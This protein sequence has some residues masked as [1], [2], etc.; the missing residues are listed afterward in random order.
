MENNIVL[1]V[2]RRLDNR[3]ENLPDDSPRA[4]E[5]HNRRK[6]AL[7]EILDNQEMIEVTN[8]GLT[9]DFNPHEYV[10]IALSL[11]T[12]TAAHLTTAW[13]QKVGEK[14][15]EKA[16]DEGTSSFV[17]WIIGKLVKKQ[18]KKE[19]LDFN[20]HLKNGT[21]IHVDPPDRDSKITVSFTNGEV[22]SISYEFNKSEQTE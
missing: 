5:L 15:A 1:G 20:I 21:I 7:H 12:W 3:F 22:A 9:D 16:I 4:L 6:V 18:K 19:I 8:W 17:K 11:V 13:L 10:E 14:L 2:F